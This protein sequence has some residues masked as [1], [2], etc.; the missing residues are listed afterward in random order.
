MGGKNT[1]NAAKPELTESEIHFLMDNTQYDRNAIIQWYNDFLRDCPD[2]KL[3][4]KEFEKVYAQLYP[5]GNPSKFSSFVFEVFDADNNKYISF[6]E[7]LLAISALSD[8]DVT[9]RLRLTFQIYDVNNNNQID[10]KEMTKVIEALYDLKSVPKDQRKGENSAAS[11]AQAIFLKLDLDG[12]KGLNADEFINGCVN[13][14]YLLSL[15][16]PEGN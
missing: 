1:K 16:L 9:K 12:S 10:I 11:R 7:F 5:K 8:G 3:D 4:K 15:L 2:G 14:N 13:D 6:S